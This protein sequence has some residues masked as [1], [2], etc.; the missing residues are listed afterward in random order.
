MNVDDHHAVP[1]TPPALLVACLC[2]RWCDLCGSYRQTFDAAAA[3]H[4]QHGFV[5]I[6][7]EDE[8]DRVHAIDVENFPTLLLTD[9]DRLLFLGV[10]T[11]HAHTLE[12]LLREAADGALPAPTHDVDDAELP[13]LLAAVRELARRPSPG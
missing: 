5:W 1:P 9:S 13:G 11:P 6:D 4:P 10:L 3:R 12:R 2:A 8:A 7:I